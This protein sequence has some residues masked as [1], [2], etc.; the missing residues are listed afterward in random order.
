MTTLLQVA[1]KTEK[2]LREIF[3]VLP[4]ALPQEGSA[5]IAG[6]TILVAIDLAMMVSSLCLAL[7][8]IANQTTD[9]KTRK[10]ILDIIKDSEHPLLFSKYTK[11]PKR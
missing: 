1:H 9:P 8:Q 2:D 10:E 7:H 11:S 3:S 4:K 5:Q 6:K